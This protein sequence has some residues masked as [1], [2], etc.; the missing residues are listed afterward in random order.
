M[1]ADIARW[2][3]KYR[4]GGD[5]REPPDS[6]I[7]EYATLFDGGVTLDVACGRG[8]NALELAA[9]GYRTWGIDGSITALVS[10]RRAAAARGVELLLV[11]ADLDTI[12]LP[13][14][15]FDLVLVVR[16]L[17]R[18]LTPALKAALRPGGLLIH[19]TFNR[20]HLS[21]TP[22]FNP[23]YLLAPG[24][25]AALYADLELVA[26][27]DGPEIREPETYWVGRRPRAKGLR[28]GSSGK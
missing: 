1:R 14:A 3:D 25:L 15:H 8:R 11:A 19:K 24:E 20:N 13:E 10:A 7:A 16:Y 4:R 21:D 28:V 27:N 2:N 26:S 23:A 6:I 5:R 9:R 18:A 17:N 22:T 12:V